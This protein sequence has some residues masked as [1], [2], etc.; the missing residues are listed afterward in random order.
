MK[1]LLIVIIF[2]IS[3][4][5]AAA[6]EPVPFSPYADFTI[7]A[8]WDPTYQDMEPMD[9][10][11]ASQKSGIKNYHLAFIT[12]AGACS[13][14][15]GAQSS[16]SASDGWGHHLTDTLTANHIA[17]TISFGGA[18]GNDLSQ[19]CTEAQLTQAYQ[20]AINTYKPE[21]LD[22]DIEN[23][24]ANVNN[25]MYA[26]QDIQKN[27]PNLKLSFTLPTLPEGLTPQ[28]ESIVSAAK[29]AGLNFTVNIMA[30]DYGPAYTE[31]MGNYA[32]LAATNLFNFL[33]TQYPEKT[34]AQIWQMIQ[35]TPMIGVNDVNVEQFT[36]ADVDTINNF[37][38]TN[39]LAGL[40]MWS[41][42]RDNPCPDKWASPTCSGNNLQTAPYDFAKRFLT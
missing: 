24:T 41:V 19:A 13:P 30:M 33:Q 8:H 1:N 25:I 2:S 10:F 4:A 36:L 29:S 23:G 21:G 28:G 12:D 32:T 7:N 9:L 34:P 37:A 26:L 14:A 42:A 15:W 27:N 5:F 17:Y 11:Q 20:R 40:S 16:Y 22:F 31:D 35:I 6:A 3:C 18:S 38:K 39:G